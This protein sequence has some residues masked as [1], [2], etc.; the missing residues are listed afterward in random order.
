MKLH[1]KAALVIA[2]LI[3]IVTVFPLVYT[4]IRH[5]SIYALSLPE[6]LISPTVGIVAAGVI[7]YLSFYFERDKK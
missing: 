4:M 2:A 3:L 6:F 7:V 5:D 1:Q